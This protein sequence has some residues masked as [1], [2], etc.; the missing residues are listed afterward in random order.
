MSMLL[1]TVGLR[2]IRLVVVLLPG[3]TFLHVTEILFFFW[4]FCCNA[5]HHHTKPV[6]SARR[7]HAVPDPIMPS[8][9]QKTR[10]HIAKKRNGEVNALHAKSRD[11]LRLHKAGVRDQRLEKLA[12]A[13]GKREQP[14]GNIVASFD[15]IRSGRE[16]LTH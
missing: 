14:I 8:S 12:A 1:P 13:R 11:S 7:R 16:S 9:L 3:Q 15:I 5:H 4:G 2:P 10:K 6:A